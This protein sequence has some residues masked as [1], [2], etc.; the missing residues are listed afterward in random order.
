MRHRG[1]LL[2]TA[3]A[4]L[5][6][7]LACASQVVDEPPEEPE[8]IEEL[9][10][11]QRRHWRG[12]VG[13][14]IDRARLHA[15]LDAEQEQALRRISAELSPDR[16]GGQQLRQRLRS[17]AADAVRTGAADSEFDARVDEAVQIFEERVQRHARALEEIH[18][19]LRP[20]QR[21]AV[22]AAL[23]TELAARPDAGARSREGFRRLASH[24]MLST[25]QID[26]LRAIKRELVEGKQRIAPTRKELLALVDAFEREDFPI[27]LEELRAKKVEIFRKRLARAGEQTDAVLQLLTAHQRELL[28]DVIEEGPGKLLGAESPSSR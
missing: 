13:V 19:L 20:E 21:A 28:A 25:F 16:P 15:S 6:A 5:L 22:A 26:K 4:G 18:A 12:P 17:S 1:L 7:A 3:T 23:R 11:K 8:R 9:T 2:L 24:L 14:L 10:A 27:A